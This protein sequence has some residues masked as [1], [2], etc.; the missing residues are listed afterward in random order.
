MDRLF[1]FGST[2]NDKGGIIMSQFVVLTIEESAQKYDLA[3][4]A[5]RRWVNVKLPFLDEEL[6]PEEAKECSWK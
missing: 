6:T 3:S 5:I 2:Q 1:L 4:Y